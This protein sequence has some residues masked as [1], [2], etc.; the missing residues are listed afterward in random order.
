M[1]INT[2]KNLTSKKVVEER[3]PLT[4]FLKENFIN[5][6]KDQFKMDVNIFYEFINDLKIIQELSENGKINIENYETF[7]DLILGLSTFDAARK[8]ESMWYKDK[9]YISEVMGAQC[10]CGSTRTVW[11]MQ[12]IRSGDEGESIMNLC[13]ACGTYFT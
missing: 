4:K 11:Q 7:D 2:K 12:Q 13:T 3:P 5:S 6:L 10:K 8:N 9:M 1:Q